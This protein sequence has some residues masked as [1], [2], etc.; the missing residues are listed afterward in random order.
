M[1]DGTRAQQ[2]ERAGLGE[3]IGKV[4]A[5]TSLCS[6]RLARAHTP[7]CLQSPHRLPHCT[8]LPPWGVGA[9]GTGGA[10]DQPRR[11]CLTRAGLR[12]R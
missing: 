11:V 9:L 2:P 7:A 3:S 10:R 5:L 4:S 1:V 8:A 12:A 6:G